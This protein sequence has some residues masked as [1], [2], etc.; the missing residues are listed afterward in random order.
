M[1]IICSDPKI[2]EEYLI[3]IDKARTE[4]KKAEKSLLKLSKM[5]PNKNYNKAHKELV[6]ARK[7]IGKVEQIRES[8]DI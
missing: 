6:R 1:C 5:Y 3:A 8:K 7:S 2:G 4:L